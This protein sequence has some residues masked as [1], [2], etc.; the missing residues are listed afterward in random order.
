[1]RDFDELT[2]E[3][4]ELLE[5]LRCG[6]PDLEAVKHLIFDTYWFLKAEL[7]GKTIP[8]HQLELYKYICQVCQSLNTEYPIGIKHSEATVFS[9]F[10][11][12]LCVVFEAGFIA[13]GK[14]HLKLDFINERS[15][16]YELEADMTTYESFDKY[17]DKTVEDYKYEDD[18]EEYE[19]E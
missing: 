3:W 13:Y 9:A 19:D 15:G 11:A 2:A 1:M 17:F 16:F 7:K 12:G 8:R 4:E 10:A 5:I 6:E 14:D 18:D